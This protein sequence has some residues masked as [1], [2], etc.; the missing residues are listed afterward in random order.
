MQAATALHSLVMASMYLAAGKLAELL[1]EKRIFVTGAVVFACGT[2]VA[3]LSPNVWVLLLG[4]SLIK[5]VGGAM[6][7]P[8]A[9]SLIVRND[10]GRQRSTAFGIFSAFVAAAAVIGP[11]WMGLLA[12]V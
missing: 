6:M 9:N 1:G 10:E 2:A 7:I 5:P 8:A 4:W 11:I 3:A 12:G